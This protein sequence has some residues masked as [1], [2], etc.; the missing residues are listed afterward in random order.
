MSST[1]IYRVALRELRDGVHTGRAGAQEIVVIDSPAGLR[2]F[3]GMCPHLGGPLLEGRI[4]RRAVVCPWHA[5]VFDSATG[6]CLTKPG[7]I[8]TSCPSKPAAT[9]PMPI[10]LRKLPHAV[11]DGM[12]EVYPPSEAP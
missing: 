5:Y 4:T 11:V 8:W 1:A 12:V 9:E 2:V 10:A 3:D 6:A 7:R